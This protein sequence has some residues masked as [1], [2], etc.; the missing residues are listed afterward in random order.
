MSL[1]RSPH[2]SDGRR[3]CTRPPSAA[4]PTPPLDPEEKAFLTLINNYRVQNGLQPLVASN[5]LSHASAW[6]SSDLGVNHYFE[7]DDTLNGTLRRTWVDR[8]RDCGYGYN[9]WLGENIAAGVQTAQQ[10]F[11]IWKN[12]PGHDANM[13]GANYTAIGIGRAYVPG[14]PYGWYW[15]T[16]FGGYDDGWVTKTEAP[17]TLPIAA[18]KLTP[19]PAPPR[20]PAIGLGAHP[21]Q[22][23]ARRL[24]AVTRAPHARS[25]ATGSAVRPHSSRSPLYPGAYFSSSS[26][27]ASA[28]SVRFL[29]MRAVLA[30]RFRPMRTATAGVF[31]AFR[32]KSAFSRPPAS[33]YSVAPSI[34]NQIST[35]CGFPVTRPTVVR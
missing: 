14:S 22:P 31:F 15:T 10:A 13:R 28:S 3:L 30:N 18:P 4:P 35:V 34:A 7:H 19:A 8:I 17:V 2:R 23:A 12:S 33:T 21:G 25:N 9:T 11:D 32:T 29:T 5:T 16:D 6:K 26:R 27:R 24:A 20:K 1:W